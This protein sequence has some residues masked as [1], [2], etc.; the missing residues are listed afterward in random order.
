[1]LEENSIYTINPAY[2]FK[3]D[4]KRV[5][6]TNNNSIFCDAADDSGEYTTSFAVVMHPYMAYIFSMFD[7]SKTIK[8]TLLCIS[9]LLG[10]GYEE[11]KETI[12][13]FVYNKEEIIYKITDEIYAPIPKNFIIKAECSV[14]RNLLEGIDL[15][16]MIKN[17]VDIKTFRYYTPNEVYFMV[18]NKCVVNCEYC[19]ADK[20]HKV[21]NPL[22]FDR[23]KELV[24]EAKKIG[25]RDFIIGGGEF[26]LYD[27]WS[28]LID[29]LNENEFAPFIS[30]KFPISEDIIKKL[31]SKKISRFQISI[32][33]INK[34][35]MKIMLNTNDNY[36]DQIL[37]TLDLLKKYNMPFRVKAV[38]TKYND[39][40]ESANELI[41]YL[42]TFDNLEQLSLA[43]GEVSLYKPFTYRTTQS[44]LKELENL[45]NEY[46]KKD[47]RVLM[48]SYM[49]DNRTSSYEEKLRAHNKRN[50]CS[51]NLLSCY[52]LPDGNVTVCEQLYWIPFFNLG[53]VRKKTIMEVWSSKKALDLW[54]IPQNKIRKSSP[55]SACKTFDFCRRGQGSCWKMAVIAYGKEN[56][57]F[58]YPL[59]PLAPPAYKDIYI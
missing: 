15:D 42:L 46:H 28:E 1:M 8:D 58:P 9:N 16:E 39:S 27:K 51:G 7:G 34:D 19:Y 41:K 52:I 21:T 22:D 20:T 5:V 50:S 29:I 12:S 2:K 37:K 59:C 11:T 44:K 13:Q 38:I 53:N 47:K 49:K 4:I 23:V 31:K 26:F 30:T 43:P 25:C 45:V 56:P 48:Q 33:T 18:N 35:E 10:I 55:C 24:V 14:V 40:I 57:D 3:N 17:G 6:V 54:N 32:D 36:C